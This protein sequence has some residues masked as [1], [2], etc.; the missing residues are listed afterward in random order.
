MSHSRKQYGLDKIH[1]KGY[2]TLE[3]YNDLTDYIRA[4]LTEDDK[5]KTYTNFDKRYSKSIAFEVNNETVVLGYKVNGNYYRKV[6]HING[7]IVRE[8][9]NSIGY[10]GEQVVEWVLIYN[11][12]NTTPVTNNLT[13]NLLGEVI[14]YMAKVSANYNLQLENSG[15]HINHDYYGIHVSNISVDNGNRLNTIDY[16]VVN[17]LDVDIKDTDISVKFTGHAI[18]NP[19]NWNSV[20]IYDKILETLT[21]E[22]GRLRKNYNAYEAGYPIP[23]KSTPTPLSKEEVTSRLAVFAQELQ[24]EILTRVEYRVE[25]NTLL[26]NLNAIDSLSFTVPRIY[27]TPTLDGIQHLSCNAND[28][29][30]LKLIILNSTGVYKDEEYD[31]DKIRLADHRKWERLTGLLNQLKPTNSTASTDEERERELQVIRN[32]TKSYMKA[33]CELIRANWNIISLEFNNKTCPY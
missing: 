19:K 26:T 11:P 18:G 24:G 21:R 3:E 5:F 23:Y 14:V 31:L 9:G 16:G 13:P 27:N 12:N 25:V 33:L 4:S 17:N 7:E 22:Q 1:I 6:E 30:F 2:G 20:V 15:V 32:C 28:R 29:A 10:N 8:K